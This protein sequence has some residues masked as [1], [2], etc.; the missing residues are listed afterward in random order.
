MNHVF[1]NV[2]WMARCVCVTYV[3]KRWHHDALWEESKGTEAVMM[4]NLDFSHSC[5][6]YPN[7]VA[8]RVH[9]FIET[10]FLNASGLFQ[11]DSHLVMMSG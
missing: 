4:G 3:E 8:D 11:Q 5:T 6:T 7:A 10:V 1:F 2:M 9:P